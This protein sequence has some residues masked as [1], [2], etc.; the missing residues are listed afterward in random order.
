MNNGNN[1]R[2]FRQGMPQVI[3]QVCPHFHAGRIAHVQTGF[4]QGALGGIPAGAAGLSES[5]LLKLFEAFNIPV[6]GAGGIV[7]KIGERELTDVI[8]EAG[9]RS[10]RQGR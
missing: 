1:R 5:A 4:L 9:D 8:V 10:Q 3:L 2:T 6:T 7:V